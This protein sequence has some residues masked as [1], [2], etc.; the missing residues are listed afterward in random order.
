MK[1]TI[2]YAINPILGSSFRK[3]LIYKIKIDYSSGASPDSEP[4]QLI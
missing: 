2:P 1:H 3:Q 4:H